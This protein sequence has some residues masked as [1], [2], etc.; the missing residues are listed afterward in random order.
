M[1]GRVVGGVVLCLIGALWIA[2]GLNVVKGSGM[3]DHPIW[4]VIG[5]IVIAVGVWLIT[6][7]VRRGRALRSGVSERQ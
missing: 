1:W 3:S 5:A 6:V 7:G 4:A 2:Q